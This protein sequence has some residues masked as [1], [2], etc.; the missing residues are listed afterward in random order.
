MTEKIGKYY[1]LFP[2]DVNGTE[3]YFVASLG[4]AEVIYGFKNR[5][6]AEESF[7]IS[8]NAAK[9][10]KEPERGLN[11]MTFYVLIDTFT[12][13][14]M[15]FTEKTELMREYKFRK[16]VDSI[17]DFDIGDH[18]RVATAW[19]PYYHQKKERYKNI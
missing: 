15:L 6:A 7:E 4:K 2:M 8:D 18:Y 17:F 1:K 16:K 11:N 9:F 10:W 13:Q 19:A 3:Y 12:K 14:I 5:K